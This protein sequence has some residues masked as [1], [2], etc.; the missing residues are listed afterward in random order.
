MNTT[1]LD[2]EKDVLQSDLPVL[3]DF[4]AA[5]CGPCKAIS[6]IID[7]LAQEYDGRAKVIKVDVDEHGDLSVK[8][9]IMSI[10]ALVLFKGGQEVDRLV[11]AASK[12]AIEQLIDKQL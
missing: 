5:W 1:K 2:F 8:H 9:G 11:G 6:P 10:P 12:Q 3:V 7:E 4:T